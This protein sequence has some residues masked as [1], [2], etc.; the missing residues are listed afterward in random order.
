MTNTTTAKFVVCPECEGEGKIGPGFVWT[1]DQIDQAD[2]DEFWE[3]QREL[4]EGQYDVRCPYCEGKR[5]V[6]AEGWEAKWEDE[7]DYR[8]EVAAERRMGC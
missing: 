5:V 2:P 4:R 1:V 8:A 6:D 3:M 7:C